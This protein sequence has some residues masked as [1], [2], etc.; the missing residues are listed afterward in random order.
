MKNDFTITTLPAWL[1][2]SAGDRIRYTSITD[3]FSI[4]VSD[5][6]FTSNV[7]QSGVWI[8]RVDG[9]STVPGGKYGCKIQLS[10]NDMSIIWLSA[11]YSGLSL[12]C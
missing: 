6:L 11:Q 5:I 1:G 3:T 12:I 4:S 2:F 9:N 8:F 7:N 10:F